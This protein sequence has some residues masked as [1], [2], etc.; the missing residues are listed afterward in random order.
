MSFRGIPSAKGFTKRYELHYHPRKMG[1]DGAEVQGQY[2]C[3]TFHA[4]MRGSVGDAHCSY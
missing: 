3:I 1:V 4:K 2:G